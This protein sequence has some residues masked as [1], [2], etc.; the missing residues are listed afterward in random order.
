MNSTVAN[1]SE[2]SRLCF[3]CGVTAVRNFHSVMRGT[4]VSPERS[5]ELMHVERRDYDA[6]C[7]RLEAAG[8]PLEADRERAWKRFIQDHMLY[9][10]EIAWLAAAL[11]DPT[12][13]WP[14]GAVKEG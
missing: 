13:F 8:V 1:T 2:G 7:E 9:E 6:A 14:Q 11:S 12:P 10:E 3:E 5:P 4:P